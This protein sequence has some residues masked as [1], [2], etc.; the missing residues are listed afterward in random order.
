MAT[1]PATT[2]DDVPPWHAYDGCYGC[3][4]GNAI[5]RRAVAALA[6]A[7]EAVPPEGA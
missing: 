2:P 1:D 5:G 6:E 7:R 3:R 4:K